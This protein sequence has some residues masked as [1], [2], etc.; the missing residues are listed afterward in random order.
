MLIAFPVAA[1]PIDSSSTPLVW[2]S[3]T[4][5]IYSPA[6]QL[7]P[8]TEGVQT[9]YGYGLSFTGAHAGLQVVDDPKLALTKSMT[10]SVYLNV[11]KYVDE[12]NSAPGAQVVFRG[13]DRSGLDP[14][15]LT[16][17]ADGTIV[18]AI[19]AA[20]GSGAY[21]RAPIALSTWTHVMATLD[22]TTGEMK[23]T[24]NGIVMASTKTAIRPFGSLDPRLLPG[25]GIGNV[26]AAVGGYHNQPFH[27][28]MADLRIYDKPVAYEEIVHPMSSR[29]FA[30]QEG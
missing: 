5:P 15:H 27:G 19:E 23:L 25:V 3:P 21:V 30:A 2:T 20:D 1:L 26:Q 12:N 14:Y 18:F 10:I 8:G 6:F 13:D 7:N 22:D 29:G 16:V 11:D 24:L 28:K 17:I 4:G 9:P